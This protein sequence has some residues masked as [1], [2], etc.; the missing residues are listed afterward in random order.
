MTGQHTADAVDD[1]VH[2]A[3]SRDASDAISKTLRREIDEIAKTKGPCWLGLRRVGRR[4]NR[5]PRPPACQLGDSLPDGATDGWCKNDLAR[6]K[7]CLRE[8]NVRRQIGNRNTSGRCIIDLVRD[9]AE[10][11]VP[12]GDPLA[13]SPIFRDTVGTGED[14]PATTPND[15]LPGSSTTP[16]PSFPK[17]KA[18]VVH[19]WP[20]DRMVWSSGVTPA[21]VTRTST[22]PSALRGLGTSTSFRARTP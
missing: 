7:A 2:A 17:S 4:P 22:L 1:N 18:A 14:D 9:E 10:I 11:F 16:A 5:P 3:V 21:A 19:G 6:L 13:V 12:H 8:G 20:P 15:E